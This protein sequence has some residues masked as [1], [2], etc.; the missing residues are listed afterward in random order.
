M[1]LVLDYL[2][3]TIDVEGTNA[4]VGVYGEYDVIQAVAATGLAR[5]FWQTRAWSRGLTSARAHLVQEI[6]TY[7]VNGVD[8]D[9]NTINAA[10]WGQAGATGEDT[11]SQTEADQVIAAVNAAR[12]LLYE[13]MRGRVPDPDHPG[14]YVDDQSGAHAYMAVS[15]AN[16]RLADPATGLPALA[17]AVRVVQAQQV[18]L[19]TRVEAVQRALLALQPA[20][21]VAGDI[22]VSGVLHATTAGPADPAPGR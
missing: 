20:A 13:I 17:A 15:T 10:D 6:G 5:W 4:L 9:R 8:C 12:D 14:K 22:T 11:M 1:G 3:G 7:V 18:D 21:P 2:R 19:A 16:R